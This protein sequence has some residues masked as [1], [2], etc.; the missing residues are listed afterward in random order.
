LESIGLQ[1]LRGSLLKQQ[2]S[3]GK[4]GRWVGEKRMIDLIVA[5]CPLPTNY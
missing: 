2:D 5:R 3:G 1:V 4:S